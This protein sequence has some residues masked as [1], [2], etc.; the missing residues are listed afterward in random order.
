MGIETMRDNTIYVPSEL[1][2][3]LAKARLVS[4]G[5]GRRITNKQ[6]IIKAVISQCKRIINGRNR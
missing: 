5:R 2:D 1:T 6:I 4:L 3:I